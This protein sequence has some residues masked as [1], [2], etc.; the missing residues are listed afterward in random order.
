MSTTKKIWGIKRE[1]LKTDQTEIDLLYL[2]RRSACSVHFHNHKI[3]RFILLS[4][5]VTI[6]TDLG[7]H[8]LVVNEPFDV[9]PRMTHQFVTTSDEAVMIETS[10]VKKGK[11]DID[12][13]DRSVQGGKFVGD[14]DKFFTLDELKENNWL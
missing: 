9:N 5:K 8:D 3:N 7:D 2:E 4:G 6:K 1:L 14:D 11:I 13:I 10:F 12:D